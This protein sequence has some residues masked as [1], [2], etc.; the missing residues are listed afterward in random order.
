M[1]YRKLG[2]T[3][4]QVSEV[5]LGCEHLE[6]K[7]YE[8]VAAVI[9]AALAGG[10]NALDVFMSEPQVR[11]DIGRALGARRRDVVLQG[12]IGAAWVDGQYLR[13]RDIDLCKT[14][15]EDLLTRLGTDYIDVGMIH[16]VDTRRDF[17]TVFGGPVIAYAQQLK[18]QGVIKCI[19]MSSHD[20]VAALEA[21]K[22]GLI[23]VL[24][25]SVNPAYD[26][27][28]GETPLD[29]MFAAQKYANAA[30]QGIHPA[31]AELYRYCAAH[32]IAITVMK[33]LAAGTLLDAARS[34]FGVAMR[35]EQCMAYC[36]QRPAVASMM[37][38]AADVAQVRAA[39]AYEEAD[40]AAKDYAEV[41][42]STPKYAVKGRCMYCNHC[43]PCP[44]H[45]DIAQVNKL[46]DMALASEGVPAASVV[47]HYEGLEHTASDCIA[48]RRCERNCPF[49]VHVIERMHQAAVL[50][51]K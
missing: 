4:M 38:G 13:T 26:L 1:L 10:I 37:L 29:D 23:D 11:T 32:D 14:Y 45:I 42:A 44:A 49:G 17:E 15:F 5:G 21:A 19:G 47:G 35:L 34:P 16:Y 8:Q 50:F 3:G 51:G 43:L 6:G 30:L 46:Y 28:P 20:P 24:M 36:L 7:P 2:R 39:L 25:F 31:R 27:M 48:C 40:D 9:D 18:A 41:L 22:T 33:G 12:H